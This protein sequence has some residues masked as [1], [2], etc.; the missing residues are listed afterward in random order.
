MK[1][2]CCGRK[3]KLFESYVAIKYEDS[4]INLC[5][6]CNDLAYKIRDDAN[7]NEKELF[8]KHL[9]EWENRSKKKS[10]KFTKWQV[11]FIKKQESVFNRMKMAQDKE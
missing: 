10:D 5:A 8:E 9:E 2:D 11:E 1:C 3:K 4:R 6:F 7:N